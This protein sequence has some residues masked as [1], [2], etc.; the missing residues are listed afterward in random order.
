MP[1]G[2]LYMIFVRGGKVEGDMG[3]IGLAI[4]M[5]LFLM[6]GLG[7]FYAGVKLGLRARGYGAKALSASSAVTLGTVPLD[8]LEWF[9][10]PTKKSDPSLGGG[11]RI[12]AEA[13]ATS[14]A[15]GLSVFALLWN[16]FVGTILYFM[17]TEEKD[18]TPIFAKAIFGVMLLAGLSILYAA[19]HA[20]ARV[21]LTGETYLDVSKELLSPGETLTWA[22]IQRGNYPI[23]AASANLV[24]RETVRYTVGTDTVTK[25]EPVR[26]IELSPP[27]PSRADP[28]RPVIEGQIVIPED[29]PSSFVMSHNR[30]EWG[31]EVELVIPG[32]PDVKSFFPIRIAPVSRG[33]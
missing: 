13:T 6:V 28:V 16:G 24:C 23:E 8:A 5:G 12:N 10:K 4:L 9:P 33:Y 18:S 27:R 26:T 32:R 21:F 11:I 1:L 14:T 25:Q 7:I 29:A 22:V 2:V 15:I 19:I 30:V 20:V 31:I 3:P 17:I